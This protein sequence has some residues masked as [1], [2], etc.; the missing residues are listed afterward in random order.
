M[1]CES[2]KEVVG[3]SSA[4]NKQTTSTDKRRAMGIGATERMLSSKNS[5]ISKSQRKELLNKGN[6]NY[7]ELG[8]SIFNEKGVKFADEVSNEAEVP[9]KV[10]EATGH[11]MPEEVTW[12]T[13]PPSLP[14][15]EGN[16]PIPTPGKTKVI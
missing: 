15:S 11:L 3:S 13:T 7:R 9:P 10:N 1:G 6:K 8:M 2:S 4:N 14:D 5:S 16:Y 12:E